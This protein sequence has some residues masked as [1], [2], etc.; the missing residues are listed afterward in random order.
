MYP[1]TKTMRRFFFLLAAVAALSAC[2]TVFRVSKETAPS[3]PWVGNTTVQ[4]LNAMGD[5]VRID[6]D[7]KGGSV[8]VYESTPD[9]N[10]PD[11]DI[12]DPDA[13]ARTRKYAYFYLDDEG[14]CYR[15]DT[16]R[17]L[18]AAPRQAYYDTDD[19]IWFDVLISVPLLL[20]SLLL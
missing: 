9:Y 16:N 19:S 12:L 15:V 17:S 11:Y 6:G 14:T 13:S 3:S 7:G 5:P 18:P 2:S 4:I 8:L 20:L 10:S 1:K